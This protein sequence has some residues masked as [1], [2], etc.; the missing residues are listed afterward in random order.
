MVETDLRLDDGRTLHIYDSGEGELPVVWHHGT[1]NLGAP[2]QPL[3]AASRRLGLR[4]VS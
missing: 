4:W 3:F 1:P 2:P